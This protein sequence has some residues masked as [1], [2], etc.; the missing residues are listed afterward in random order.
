[1]Q[2]RSTIFFKASVTDVRN[3]SK[4]NAKMKLRREERLLN[5][6]NGKLIESMNRKAVEG[7]IAV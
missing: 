3:F 6:T 1:L 2:R 5:Q 7:V 4:G